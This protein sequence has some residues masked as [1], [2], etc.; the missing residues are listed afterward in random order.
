MDRHI[1]GRRYRRAVGLAFRV[2]LFPALVAM[3]VAR[4]LLSM[5]AAASF[6]LVEVGALVEEWED[7]RPDWRPIA[8]ADAEDP[9]DW[10]PAPKDES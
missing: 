3:L 8:P 4:A 2:A 9:M 1:S 7:P 6:K 5:I 10:D